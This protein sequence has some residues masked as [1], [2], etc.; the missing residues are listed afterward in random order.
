[1]KNNKKHVFPKINI[2]SNH[3]INRNKFY[4][5]FKHALKLKICNRLRN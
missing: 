3:D 1:M 2:M 5:F 4:N